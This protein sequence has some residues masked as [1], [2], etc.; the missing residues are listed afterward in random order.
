MAR[1]VSETEVFAAAE[2][3]LAGGAKPTI[4]RVRQHLGRGSPAT[5]ARLLEAWW[6]GLVQR[7][8]ATRVVG[9]P[10]LPAPVAHAMQSLWEAA[11]DGAR[12]TLDTECRRRSMELDERAAVLEAKESEFLAAGAALAARA[13]TAERALERITLLHAE[14]ERRLAAS[15]EERAAL[16]QRLATAERQEVGLRAKRDAALASASAE[17]ARA[18]A[19][20]REMEAHWLRE[21]DRA[22]Q[23]ERRLE[24]QLQ[25]AQTR[26]QRVESQ[27]AVARDAAL[28]RA[29][30]AEKEAGAHE[31]VR[32]TQEAQLVRLLS[33]RPL[34]QAAPGTRSRQAIGRGVPATRSRKANR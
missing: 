5:V 8:N 34:E 20:E 32:R 13:Q 28:A 29:A 26:S 4:E 24:K 2:A 25:L 33:R 12:A 18:E 6:D 7:F 22:R 9:L 30:K 14:A 16:A 15:T 17:R 1:G 21:V 19:R 31:A 3:V 11:L 10:E 23:A 27:L